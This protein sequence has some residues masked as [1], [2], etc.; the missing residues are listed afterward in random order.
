MKAALIERPGVLRVADVPVP[1]PGP[2]EALVRILACSICN[3]TDS[4]LLYG[5][6]PGVKNYPSILGHESVGEVVELGSNVRRYRVGDLVMRPGARY[7]GNSPCHS[8]WGGF[9]E[10]GLIKDASCSGG[11]PERGDG[12]W[13]DT[14]HHILPPGTD[15]VEATIYI[16]LKETLTWLQ[17]FDLRPNSSVLILGTGPVGLSFTL[18]SKLMGAN[19]VITVGRRKVRLELAERFGAD[20]TINSSEEDLKAAVTEI[21]KG[22]GVDRIVEAIGNVEILKEALPLLSDGGRIGVYGVPP[23]DEASG[24]PPPV[25]LTTSGAPANWSVE[26]LQPEEPKGHRQILDLVRL[27]HLRP[28]DFVTE[29]FPLDR[30]GEGFRLIEER[31]ALKVVITMV[32]R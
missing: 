25:T 9:A 17:R 21:T 14:M 10:Y 16:T 29:V 19:P 31:R 23:S 27:G 18:F 30:I 2:D 8:H 12:S 5:K 26:V 22:R 13:T 20:F 32:D 4:K 6:F 1:E 11:S 28:R 7:P 3:G 15:P 24:G